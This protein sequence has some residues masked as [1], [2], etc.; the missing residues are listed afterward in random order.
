MHAGPADVKRFHWLNDKHLVE[1]L[2]VCG[3]SAFAS[4]VQNIEKIIRAILK[5]RARQ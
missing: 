2:E 1:I 4:D 5:S 3:V